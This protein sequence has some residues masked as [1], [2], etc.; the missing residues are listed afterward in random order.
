MWGS[1]WRKTSV[2][3]VKSGTCV[4][5]RENSTGSRLPIADIPNGGPR[6]TV[7]HREP[8]LNSVLALWHLKN[9][10]IS[11]GG[12]PGGL[13]RLAIRE[14]IARSAL[15]FD[16]KRCSFSAKRRSITRISSTK[17]S[18]SCSL[19]ASSQSCCQGS[20]GSPFMGTM[21]IPGRQSAN[22]STRV[23]SHTRHAP[24]GGAKAIN[25]RTRT[26]PLKGTQK[27]RIGATP[28]NC[29]RFSN[30]EFKVIVG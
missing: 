28:G 27:W 24:I 4:D 22:H 16:L 2:A 17:W 1:D 14:L 21:N 15:D 13:L 5:A 12:Y 7:L 20:R 6:R 29:K 25:P 19:A 9:W 11:D 8:L 10:P 26:Y 23:P 3:K 30:K 18:G